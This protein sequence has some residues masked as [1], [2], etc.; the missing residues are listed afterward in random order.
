[1]SMSLISNAW[2]AIGGPRRAV[3]S[4]RSSYRPFSA[5]AISRRAWDALDGMDERFVFTYEDVDFV[6][7][8]SELGYNSGAVNQPVLH[9]RHSVTSGDQVQAVL[10]VSAFAALSYLDKWYPGQRRN[11]ILLIGALYVRYLM[12]MVSKGDRGAH[13]A[14]TRAA[15]RAIRGRAT[16]SLPDWSTT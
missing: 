12:I 11:R 4:A 7:R 15:I 2:H 8:A 13:R 1:G 6:R 5:V 10:P 3:H 9:H 16:P 14:G